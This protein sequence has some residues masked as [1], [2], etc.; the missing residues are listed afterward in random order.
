MDWFLILLFLVVVMIG[1][2]AYDKFMKKLP[3]LP[4]VYRDN[5]TI[6]TINSFKGKGRLRDE[7]SQLNKYIRS[8]APEKYK[9]FFLC[10]LASVISS[11]I[12][13]RKEPDIFQLIE[14]ELWKMW[15]VV[16]CLNEAKKFLHIP[17]GEAEIFTDDIKVLNSVEENSIDLIVTSPPYSTAIDYVKKDLAQLILMELVESPKELD[18][19]MMGTHRKTSDFDTLSLHMTKSRPLH[20]N[21]NN[22][23]FRLP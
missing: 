16:Y 19:K 14:K 4:E 12:K 15:K 13:M 3:E 9:D 7:A 2:L 18:E 17:I 10:A 23:F 21:R 22:R 11:A 20:L 6:F 8:Q 5:K 1:K